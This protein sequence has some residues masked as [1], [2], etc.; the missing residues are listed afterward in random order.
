MLPPILKEIITTKCRLP[1]YFIRFSI[2]KAFIPLSTLFYFFHNLTLNTFR[3]YRP[4][5]VVQTVMDEE[6][7]QTRN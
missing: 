5:K 2:D 3:R 7:E 1:L 4:K 6:P